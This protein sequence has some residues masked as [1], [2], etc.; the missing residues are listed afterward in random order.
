MAD[1]IRPIE[2]FELTQL[3]G[4]NAADY[5]KFGLIGHN[6]WDFRTKWPDT[7]KGQR[8]ILSPWQSQFYGRG[9]EGNSG[10][11][12]YF[13]TTIKLIN[14]Y[15]LTFAHCLSIETF[16]QKKEGETMAISDNTGN[17]TGS[18][19]HLTVKRGVLTN[20]KFINEAQNNG[21]FGAIN[22][23]IFFDELRKVKNTAAVKMIGSDVIL[24]IT[25]GTGSD[26]DK[27]VKIRLLCR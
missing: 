24:A 13:E 5:A 8:Y 18:H 11:G 22:P 17:S 1:I 23:Q 10:Y 16:T 20:G 26:G 7:P 2:P 15:K 4:V 3:F 27:L 12:L 21:Y 25:E 6:G 19:L 14:H 9:N